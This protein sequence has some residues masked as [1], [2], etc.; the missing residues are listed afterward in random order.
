MSAENV[1]NRPA[2]TVR[3][4]PFEA[5][6]RA[7]E[8]RKS[9]V[10]LRLSGQPFEILAMLLERPGDV[11]TRE[12]LRRRL[13]PGDTFVDYEHSVNAAINKLREALSDSADRP[14]YVETLPRRGYRFIAPV[15]T[16]PAA[17]AP[18]PVPPPGATEAPANVPTRKA[19]IAAAML[20][21]A[22][23]LGAAW[24]AAARRSASSP[25]P[26]A[27]SGV[28]ALAVLPFE[29]LSRDPEQDYFADGIT[30]ELISRLSQI[31]SLRVVSRTSVMQYRGARQ[32]LPE[33]A[34]R[35]QVDAIVEGTVQREGDRVAIFAS[36]VDANSDR[37]L[38]S[39]RYEGD[40]RDVLGLQSQVAAA[41]AEGIRAP[42]GEE[43]RRIERV[44]P[45]DP[46]A[47]AAFLKGRYYQEKWQP[48]SARRA[49]EQ[50][51][52]SLDR[53]PG[54]APAW[55][56][57]AEAQLFSY[58][59]RE[60]MPRAKAA[61]LRGLELDPTLPEAHVVLGLTLAYWDWD[62]EGSERAFRR[63]LELDPGASD[64][65]YRYAHL[66]AARGRFD[67]AIAECRRALELDPLGGPAG[68][69]LGRIYYF[70]RRYD[71][72]IAQLRR[73]YELDR[74]DYWSN[75]FLAIAYAHAGQPDLAE[76]YLERS[77][78]LKGTPFEGIAAM[79]AAYRRGGHTAALR[80]QL[81]MET[82]FQG[83]R[84]LGSSA[85]ALTYAQI[86][87]KE[88]ALAW[89]ERSLESHPRD[90]IYIDVEPSYDS[91]RP[92]PRFQAIARRVRGRG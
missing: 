51:R 56:R 55:V 62:W 45:V 88:Q 5:D 71:E 91:I 63:A 13:W 29:T 24:Y 38:W 79:Q 7:G 58:P 11:V 60:A 76:P 9:G 15:A 32:A 6:P 81:E 73:T 78:M 8:L 17:E 87:E 48:W 18:A 59:P 82:L 68:H 46:E 64:A 21:M 34:R 42:S 20:G 67:E 33:I 14:V 90:L 41:I 1:S 39:G 57:L 35:L 66:L 84:P 69:F 83:T 89:L 54:F 53:D 85:V 28:R 92:D 47:Y 22:V 40:P 43:K 70:A 31:R 50:F 72:A 61:V 44:R 23:V 25:P 80:Q 52:E 37:T 4:G 12:E 16:A 26:A 75:L 77:A 2:G 49:I 3:F 10:K 74:N 19:G 30:E 86:G 36:L 65:H 27:L